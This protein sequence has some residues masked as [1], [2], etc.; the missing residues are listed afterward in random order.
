MNGDCSACPCPGA[1]LRRPS[2]CLWA[3]EEPQDPLK[4]RHIIAR[5]AVGGQIYFSLPPLPPRPNAVPMISVAEA[6]RL[7]RIM[8]TCPYRNAVGCGC[9]GARCGLRRGKI[10][11]HIEC[12]VCLQRYG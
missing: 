6:I 5:S 7:T 1:C 9:A 12:F 3:A 2:F 10:V 4:I 8:K 11:S